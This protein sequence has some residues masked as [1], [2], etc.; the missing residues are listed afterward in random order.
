MLSQNLKRALLDSRWPLPPTFLLPWTATLTTVSHPPS[1]SN[2]PPPPAPASPRVQ[3]DQPVPAAPAQANQSLSEIQSLVET[4]LATPQQTPLRLSDSVRTLLPSLQSQTP[5]F[6]TAHIHDRP[7]LLTAGD[8]VR[9]PFFMKGVEP[10]DIL[11]LN[12][13]SLIGSREYTLKASA[14]APKLRSATREASSSAAA[15][16]PTTAADMTQPTPSSVEREEGAAPHFIPHIA[17]GKTSYLDDRLFVCRAV[18]MG[19]ESEPMREKTKTKRRNRKIK[20]VKSKLRYT[21]LRVKEVTVR[22]LDELEGE[23]E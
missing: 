14:A 12:C 5:H 10:G 6:I 15:I 1:A 21:V 7:Y 23:V 2:L 11:R 22:G 20:T 3:R 9:L 4:Q 18:V 13:A 17:K 19:V 8:T 16:E